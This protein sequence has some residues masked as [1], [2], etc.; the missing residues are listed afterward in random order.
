M[1]GPGVITLHSTIDLV[2]ILISTTSKKGIRAYLHPKTTLQNCNSG[3]HLFSFH[4]LTI[5]RTLYSRLGEDSCDRQYKPAYALQ[6]RE[7]DT[8]L[9]AGLRNENPSTENPDQA[10][11][12]PGL[13]SA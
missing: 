3:P 1:P 6:D 9:G 13:S 10:L 5:M 12:L 11:S 8:P 2:P 7:A 4:R